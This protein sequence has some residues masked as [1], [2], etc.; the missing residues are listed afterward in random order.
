MTMPAC[1]VTFPQKRYTCPRVFV[2][3]GCDLLACSDRA[4]AVTCSPACRVRVHRH[5]ERLRRMEAEAS[6]C[7]I[8]VPAILDATALRRL[9]PD[10]GQCVM[11]GTMEIDDTRADVWRAFYELLEEKRHDAKD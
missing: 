8:N 9:R 4:H 1:R 6:A 11:A 3:I 7:H 2:C 10:L 5:P